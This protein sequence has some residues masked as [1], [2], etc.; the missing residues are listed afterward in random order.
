MTSSAVVTSP[1]RGARLA[2]SAGF[3][4]TAFVITVTTVS[5][6]TH[7]TFRPAWLVWAAT[8]GFVGVALVAGL[9]AWR[10]AVAAVESAGA[11]PSWLVAA[12]PLGFVVNSQVCGPGLTACSVPCALINLGLIGL[13]AVLALRLHRAL[14]IGPVPVVALAALGLVPH[15]VCDVNANVLWRSS[16][17][18]SPACEAPAVALA[19]LG[20]VTARGL[21]P[22]A[23]SVAVAALFAMIVFMAL[24][25]H[26]LGFPWQSCI[27]D[28]H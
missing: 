6:A 13:G 26:L 19:L 9:W 3:L 10:S 14:P 17:G 11:A 4:L 2:L 23:G 21:W 8:V 27:H 28:T 16:I 20:L 22:R 24:G 25:T 18:L 15:C 12:I 1:T 5:F 7:T